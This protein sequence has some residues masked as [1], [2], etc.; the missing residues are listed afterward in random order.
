[1]RVEQAKQFRDWFDGL[2]DVRAQAR[3]TV[4]IRKL[5]LG[6]MGAA[7]SVGDGIH[8]LRIAYGAG[9]RIYF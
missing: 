1:M 5:T 2:R 9:Y 6:N 8:E 7:K 3:I 4:Q